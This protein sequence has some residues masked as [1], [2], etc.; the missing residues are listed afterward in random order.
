LSHLANYLVHFAEDF[1]R[2]TDIRCRLDIPELLP[3]IPISANQR[4]HLL[5]ATKEACNNVVRH[6]AATEVWVRLTVTEDQF[7]IAVEDNGQG[8]H[9][10][11]VPVDHD[12]LLN[13]QQRLADLGGRVE[14]QS[15]PGQGTRVR[16]IAPLTPQDK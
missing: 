3:G 13:I 2:L 5:L 1:F 10:G 8:F 12:G 4:H 9:Q 11:A 14:L 15:A 6:S 16:I 7:T